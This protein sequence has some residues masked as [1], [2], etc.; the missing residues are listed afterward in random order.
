M[1]SQLWANGPGVSLVTVIVS[2]YQWHLVGLCSKMHHQF[3]HFNLLFPLA[4]Q[5][6]NNHPTLDLG[7]KEGGMWRGHWIGLDAHLALKVSSLVWNHSSKRRES[8]GRGPELAHT[9]TSQPLWLYSSASSRS[10]GLRCADLS[11]TT[12]VVFA[13]WLLSLVWVVATVSWLFF[14]DSAPSCEER[15]HLLLPLIT[16]LAS[17]P[18]ALYMRDHS[19]QRILRPGEGV[20]GNESTCSKG[21]SLGL[22]SSWPRAERGHTQVRRAENRAPAAPKWIKLPKKKWLRIM[23]CPLIVEGKEENWWDFRP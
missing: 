19:D 23:Q 16:A 13:S 11:L 18:K 20:A 5:R 3:R 2:S 9:Q 21:S 14:S 15:A 22:L 4:L 1:E 17:A 6:L 12:S 8:S 7:D 10:W